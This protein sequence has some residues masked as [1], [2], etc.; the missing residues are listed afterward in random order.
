MTWRKLDDTLAPHTPDVPPGLY[1]KFAVARTDGRDQP[2]GDREGARYFVL[3]LDHDPYAT[4]AL[5]MYAAQCRD[6]HPELA[7]DITAALVE[8]DAERRAGGG[9]PP[10]RP[11]LPYALTEAQLIAVFRA[12]TGYRSDKW[13]T[14]PPV[15][16]DDD[17][18]LTAALRAIG[19]DS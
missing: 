5:F 14:T 10:I 6:E 15:P 7:A 13:H 3:D 12:G 4:A 17:S 19:V 8:V 9:Q 2:G 1:E 18:L 16:M 11:I